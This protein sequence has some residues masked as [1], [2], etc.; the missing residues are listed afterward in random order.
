MARERKKAANKAFQ[1]NVQSAVSDYNK[2]VTSAQKTLALAEKKGT[3]AQIKQAKDIVKQLNDIAPMIEI[4]K[5]AESPTATYQGPI[6]QSAADVMN[7]QR[8]TGTYG[9]VPGF[10]PEIVYAREK[11]VAGFEGYSPDQYYVSSGGTGT[12]NT[13]KNYINGRLASPQEWASFLSGA[14]P[15]EDIS[16]VFGGGAA[17]PTGGYDVSGIPTSGGQYDSQGNFVGT[18]TA[19]GGT[20]GSGIGTTGAFGTGRT[21]ARDT[22]KKTLSSFFGESEAAKPWVEELYNAVSKLYLGG[23]SAEEAFNIALL[24]ARN[25]PN[26]K[27]FTDRF[28]GIYALQDLKQAGKPVIV[29]TI[30][31]YVVSQAKMGDLLKQAN[32]GDLATDEFTT[33]LISKGNSVSAVADKISQVYNRIDLAPKEIKDTFARSFPTVDRPTLARTILL[34]ERGTRELVDE[35]GKL[36][37]LAAAEQQGIAATP[38]RP[39]GLTPERAREY[40]L[41]GETFTSAMPKFQRVAQATPTISKLAGISRRAD[42]GQAGV[43]SAVLKGTAS[44]LEE[45]QRLSEEEE[46]R[47]RARAGRVETGLASQRRASRSGF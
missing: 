47:F 4:L 1:S 38:E 14:T 43:E 37:V 5:R 17:S 39:G 18:S 32:L 11:D 35:L 42:I 44:Q 15:T 19:G 2:S 3:P 16:S 36:E 25:N 21:L 26:L 28:R 10:Q 46:A 23:S 33:D 22:F 34:G 29:P 6:T 27:T 20:V 7:Q 40:A 9:G 12:S 13:G 41:M 30:A 24:D 45:I 31:E 8:A